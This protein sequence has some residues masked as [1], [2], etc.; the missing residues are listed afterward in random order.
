MYLLIIKLRSI[1]QMQLF[2]NIFLVSSTDDPISIAISRMT[3]VLSFCCTKFSNNFC[4]SGLVGEEIS[5]NFIITCFRSASIAE[6]LSSSKLT[7][8]FMLFSDLVEIVKS[9]LSARRL[10]YQRLLV[11][12]PI[13][14]IGVITVEL[15]L[16]R[17]GS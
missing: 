3:L 7:T 2:I 4:F 5:I 17:C 1:N 6:F 10:R 11:F 15:C 8:D 9:S 14:A 12:S 16:I 13:G